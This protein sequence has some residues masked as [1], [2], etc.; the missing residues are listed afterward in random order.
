MS[1]IEGIYH[2]PDTGTG[3]RRTLACDANGRLLLAP[4]LVESW[5]AGA[6]IPRATFTTPPVDLGEA[7][8]YTL[9]IARKSGIASKL[10]ALEIQTSVDGTR[11][12]PAAGIYRNQNVAWYRPAQGSEYFTVLPFIAP[13][14][15][16]RRRKLCRRKDIAE[17]FRAT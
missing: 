1:V 4:T 17:T 7:T 9:L 12:L 5:N 10:E 2:N 8:A 6:M 11:W 13:G 15:A 14:Q 16:W 3:E